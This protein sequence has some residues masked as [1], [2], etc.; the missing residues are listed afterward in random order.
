MSDAFARL[1]RRTV[2]LA[3]VALA[4]IGVG[5]AVAAIPA[6][7]GTIHGCFAT[8]GGALRVI[9]TGQTCTARSESPLTWNQTG[10]TGPQGAKGDPGAQG[11]P[12]AAGQNGAPGIARGYAFIDKDGILGAGASGVGSVS[13]PPGLGVTCVNFNFTAV[14]VVVTQSADLPPNSIIPL[15]LSIWVVHNPSDCSSGEWGIY[16]QNNGSPFFTPI[17]I[18]AN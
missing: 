4:A 6:A 2:A 7:D 8:K 9:D 1:S 5:A 13:R 12:G 3:L 11:P 10:P 16:T 17:Y 18:L 14:S 15:N